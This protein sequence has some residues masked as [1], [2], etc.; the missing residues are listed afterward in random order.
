MRTSRA[1]IKKLQTAINVRFG[2]CLLINTSQWY[3]DESKRPITLYSIRKSIWDED[4][5]KRTNVELFKSYS[6]LQII[7]WLRDY[8]YTLNGW[9]LPV[10]NETWNI[11]RED[12]KIDGEVGARKT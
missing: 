5:G 12:N 4:K 2:A 11:I 3:S 10:D 8:W 9:E 1:M 7:L 6:Q